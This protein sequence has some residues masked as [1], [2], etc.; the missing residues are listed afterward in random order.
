MKRIIL[1]N[2]D[3]QLLTGKSEKTCYRIMNKIRLQFGKSNDR[4][5]TIM[6]VCAYWGFKLDEVRVKLRK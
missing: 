3:L 1:Y 5:I 4:P 6:D 2:K